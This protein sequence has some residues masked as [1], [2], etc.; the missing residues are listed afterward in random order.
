MTASDEQSFAQAKS[1]LEASAEKLQ[2]QAIEGQIA[3][4]C[5]PLPLRPL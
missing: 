3:I 4:G 5:R 2:Y 1:A